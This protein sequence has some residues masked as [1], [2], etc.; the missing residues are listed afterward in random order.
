VSLA[1]TAAGAAS[2]A[3]VNTKYRNT[4]QLPHQ[5]QSPP[6]SLPAVAMEATSTAAAAAAAG[7]GG[8][9]GGPGGVDD[10]GSVVVQMLHTLVPPG[11]VGVPG[12]DPGAA[13]A[14]AVHACMLAAGFQVGW[15]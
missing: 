10:E 6:Q 13:L 1:A 9:A 11:P 12:G 15:G 14:L 5:K 3:A 8:G 2:A 7:G 4:Y